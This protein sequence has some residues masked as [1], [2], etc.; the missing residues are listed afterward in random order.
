MVSAPEKEM[1]RIKFDQAVPQRGVGCG[2][3]VKDALFKA[4]ISI[5]QPQAH[6]ISDDFR[7]QTDTTCTESCDGHDAAHSTDG[8]EYEGLEEVGGYRLGRTI[9]QGSFGEVVEATKVSTIEKFALKILSPR[10]DADKIAIEQEIQNHQRLHHRHVVEIKEV[11]SKDNTTYI[12][13][14]LLVGEELFDYIVRQGR[15]RE[16]DARRVFQQII[17][18][19][20]HC[21]SNK[22]AHLDLKPENIFLT[23]QGVKI[24]DFGLS[25][26]IKDGKLLTSDCGTAGYTAPEVSGC[27]YEGRAADIF[28]CGIILFTLLCGHRPFYADSDKAERRLISKGHFVV[29]FYV[30][31]PTKDLIQRMLIVNPKERISLSSIQAHPWLTS[32]QD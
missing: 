24:I 19:V 30:S 15:L 18:G 7:E 28:S 23:A 5:C 14:D 13:M 25:A 32:S 16:R 10:T 22:V 6:A 21:H 3:F 4:I 9:G 17:A 26:T 12:V 2:Q 11:L 31:K 27:Q 8:S 29:P 20:E 1:G